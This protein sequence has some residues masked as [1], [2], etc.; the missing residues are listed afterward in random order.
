[1]QKRLVRDRRQAQHT[2]EAFQ[3]ALDDLGLPADLVAE[4][5]G[6][7]RSQQ[8]RLCNICGVMFPR[9]SDAAPTPNDAACG[10]GIK[11]C[12]HTCSMRYPSAPGSS[13]P[14]L[15]TGGVGTAVELCHQPECSHGEPL[16]V[17]L[18][19]R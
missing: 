7:L 12:P 17:D 13:V 6:H 5:E 10:A 1:V 11:T 19:G 2:A 8:Q 16:A 3:Q 14:T 4:I 18:G 9:G 15:G